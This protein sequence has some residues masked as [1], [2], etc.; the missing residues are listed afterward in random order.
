MLHWCG[1]G[2]GR[3]SFPLST[4]WERQLPPGIKLPNPLAIEWHLEMMTDVVAQKTT[5]CSTIHTSTSHAMTGCPLVTDWGQALGS[6]LGKVRIGPP[7]NSASI[8]VNVGSGE[9]VR[10]PNLYRETHQ[11][12]TEPGTAKPHVV[13]CKILA[14]GRQ[15]GGDVVRNG[16]LRCKEQSR[17]LF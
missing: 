8:V 12:R 15:G 7:A 5:V 6:S 4:C 1:G 11:L 10:E 17:K 2:G 16:A 13:A 14:V 3:R 9:G